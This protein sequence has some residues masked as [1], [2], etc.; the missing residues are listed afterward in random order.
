MKTINKKYRNTNTSTDRTILMKLGSTGRI[1]KNKVMSRR[2]YTQKHIQKKLR[3]GST[4][5]M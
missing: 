4:M 5:I 2:D 3:S 1:I